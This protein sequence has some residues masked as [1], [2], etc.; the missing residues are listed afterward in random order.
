M[1]RRSPEQRDQFKD[2]LAAIGL[3]IGLLIGGGGLAWG[4]YETAQ[5]HQVVAQN[6]ALTQALIKVGK[7]H[8][9]ETVK[10]DAQ[11][12]TLLDQVKGLL[13]QHSASFAQQQAYDADVLAFAQTIEGEL[14][15]LCSVSAASCPALPALTTTTTT[16]TTGGS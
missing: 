16:T 1:V 8:H 6:K 5:T 4:V 15:A 2:K 13:N 14:T 3:V 9:A 12:A 11:L 10:K 7:I